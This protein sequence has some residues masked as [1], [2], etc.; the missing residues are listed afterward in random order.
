[1][2]KQKVRRNVPRV[3]AF[4]PSSLTVN[5]IPPRVLDLFTRW[6]RHG[7]ANCAAINLTR[8]A[9]VKWIL[10][11]QQGNRC[12]SVRYVME[13]LW[14]FYDPFG[15]NELPVPPPSQAALAVEQA[16][17]EIEADDQKLAIA[18]NLA[19]FPPEEVIA[20][21]DF[22]ESRF[23]FRYRPLTESQRRAVNHYWA[24]RIAL[25]GEI[26]AQ[27]AKKAAYRD[28]SYFFKVCIS[29]LSLTSKF[30]AVMTAGGTVP[31]HAR[32]GAWTSMDR[33]RSIVGSTETEPAN[34]SMQG[35]PVPGK[36]WRQ[37]KGMEPDPWCEKITQWASKHDDSGFSINDVCRKCLSL[38]PSE[39]DDRTSK[40]VARCL[41]V[42]GYEPKKVRI[43]HSVVRRWLPALAGSPRP[44]D[45][46]GRLEASIPTH[47]QPV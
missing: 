31:G 17:G 44:A 39:W 18:R 45:G 42:A 29:A 33:A 46:N 27:G 11:D 1:M 37:P 32:P 36:P 7:L 13:E 21:W 14:L 43:G 30:L 10:L 47:G 19:G 41:R 6:H 3:K 15:R 34:I 12:E 26:F 35:Q 23:R 40:R 22:W 20:Q 24:E 38:P 16:W 28:Y 8:R 4:V 5:E 9:G 25:L 2:F